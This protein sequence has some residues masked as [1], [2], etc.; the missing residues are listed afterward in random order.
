MKEKFFAILM[1]LTIS[2]AAL[3]EAS[4]R[5][6]GTIEIAANHMHMGG[7]NGQFQLFSEQEQ[8]SRIEIVSNPAV[9]GITKFPSKEQAMVVF[10]S[11][12][13]IHMGLVFK[14]RGPA[15]TWYYAYKGSSTDQGLHFSGKIFRA[16]GQFTDIQAQLLDPQTPTQWIEVGTAELS[17]VR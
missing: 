6:N 4:L 1:F 15:H 11:G 9:F 2:P 7:V 8:L 10:P 12:T 14:L 16:D 3:A 5:Y 17:A 13:N